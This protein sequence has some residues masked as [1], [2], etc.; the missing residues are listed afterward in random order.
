MF[1]K[2]PSRFSWHQVGR[3]CFK[4]ISCSCW[5]PDLCIKQV[6]LMCQSVSCFFNSHCH[7]LQLDSQRY[8]SCN[9]TSG[10]RKMKIF[11]LL[12][13]RKDSRMSEF[14]RG[15]GRC[16]WSVGW[17]IWE[18]SLLSDVQRPPAQRSH[19]GTSK[20]SWHK[21]KMEMDRA[22]LW[23]WR[24]LSLDRA[25][26]ST[27]T[28]T[29]CPIPTELRG[30]SPQGQQ[31]NKAKSLSASWLRHP[32]SISVCAFVSSQ[33]LW[34]HLCSPGLYDYNRDDWRAAALLSQYEDEKL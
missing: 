19:L 16:Q 31:H 11:W 6:S 1:G 7:M 17:D 20:Q 30:N 3:F 18:T 10:V 34:Q 23:G 24:S 15:W 2:W 29:D 22:L 26:N 28:H 4:H 25:F 32:C 12:K 9:H 5:A 33:V 14:S 21:L 13:V 8:Y 27:H